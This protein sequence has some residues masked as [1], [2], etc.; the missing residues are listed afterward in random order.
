MQGLDLNLT[1]ERIAEPELRTAPGVWMIHYI[2]QAGE[3]PAAQTP[4]QRRLDNGGLAWSVTDMADGFWHANHRSF[5][6]KFGTGR[7]AWFE[8]RS[9]AIVNVWKSQPAVVGRVYDAQNERIQRELR[10]GVR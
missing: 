3:K 2:G 1:F 7:K 5:G 8:V 9:G 4:S 10:G 6:S